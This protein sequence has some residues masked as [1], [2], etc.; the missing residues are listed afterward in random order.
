[1]HSNLAG[2][3]P[4]PHFPYANFIEALH[5]AV[6]QRNPIWLVDEDDHSIAEQLFISQFDSAAKDHLESGRRWSPTATDAHA[7][8]AAVLEDYQLTERGMLRRLAGSGDEQLQQVVYRVIYCQLLRRTRRP[9]PRSHVE[10]SAELFV[11]KVLEP[12]GGWLDQYDPSKAS[13]GT[14]LGK[15]A[16]SGAIPREQQR[17]LGLRRR[18][19][20]LVRDP[21][22]FSWDQETVDPFTEVDERVDRQRALGRLER[23][24][25]PREE[26]D[27][28]LR[29]KFIEDKSSTQI[30]T[31]GGFASGS[32]VRAR[33]SDRLKVLREELRKHGPG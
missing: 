6:T 5:D 26:W 30:A 3:A 23:V 14:F 2:S 12:E 13:L 33:L 15:R 28:L 8:A 17:I 16:L 11:R 10:L 27:D 19:D 24:A 22:T 20:E 29:M 31:E 21:D 9:Y 25:G 4:S 7:W 1:M 18:K 32:A